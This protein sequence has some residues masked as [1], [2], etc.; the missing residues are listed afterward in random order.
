MLAPLA[1]VTLDLAMPSVASSF[2]DC[3]QFQHLEPNPDAGTIAPWSGINCLS[4][5]GDP[6]SSAQIVAF[7][8]GRFVE[9]GAIFL[10][11]EGKRLSNGQLAGRADVYLSIP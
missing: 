3:A 4:G 6:S 1:G 8:L 2:G 10:R 5:A 7:S 9:S 11:Y